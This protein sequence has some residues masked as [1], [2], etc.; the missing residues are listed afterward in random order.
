MQSN[1]NVIKR[2][3]DACM[4]VILLCLMAYQ[5]TGDVL[6]EWIGIGMTGIFT[7]FACIGLWLFIRNG[8]PSYLTFR[9]HFAFLDYDKPAIL[10]FAEN[11]A[12]LFF[13]VFIGANTVRIIRGVN[14]QQEKKR[15]RKWR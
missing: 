4:T 11:L 7:V 15:Y 6:H 1:K 3:A 2:I 5:V 10:V 9:T 13:F 8:I 12:E 14:R